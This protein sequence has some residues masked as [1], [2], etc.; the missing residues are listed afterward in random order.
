MKLTW[1]EVKRRSTLKAHDLDFADAGEVFSGIHLEFPDNRRDYGETR[2]TTVGF[3]RGRMVVLVYTPR[4]EA[5]HII[6]M[7]KA[8]GRE[9][10]RYQA[11]L[12]GP[13]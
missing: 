13:G 8:N 10:G 2:T 11:R 5:R 4:G 7:R 6:S 12:G 3:M 9:I 1:D